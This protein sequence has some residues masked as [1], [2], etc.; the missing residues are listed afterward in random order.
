[1]IIFAC[2]LL[3]VTTETP[4]FVSLILKRVLLRLAFVLSSPAADKTQYL[5]HLSFNST[6]QLINDISSDLK[7]LLNYLNDTAFV[8]FLRIPLVSSASV[9]SNN[10]A[11]YLKDLKLSVFSKTAL[12]SIASSLE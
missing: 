2:L 3:I 11:L 9:F 1:M 8:A 12:K 4:N 6:L 10:L 7:K 5:F